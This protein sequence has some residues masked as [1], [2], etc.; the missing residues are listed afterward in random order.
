MAAQLGEDASSSRGHPGPGPPEAPLSR[1]RR[2]IRRQI[3]RSA[4]TG[5][6]G[7]GQPCRSADVY[8]VAA[9]PGVL[10]HCSHVMSTAA[11]AAIPGR[12]P[13]FSHF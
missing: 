2:T 8:E 7:S 1:A 13:L 12:A 10:V 11:P 3:R 6:R 5:M 9:R 4:G